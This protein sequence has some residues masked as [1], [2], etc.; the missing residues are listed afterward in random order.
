[1]SRIIIVITGGNDMLNI[2]ESIKQCLEGVELNNLTIEQKKSLSNRYNTMIRFEY[3]TTKYNE[4]VLK[5]NKDYFGSMEY[6]YGFEYE[7]EN[8]ILKIEYE[9]DLIVIYANDNHNRV[10]EL[11]EYLTPEQFCKE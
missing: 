7:R 2:L 5:M 3:S 8:I 10:T 9:E 4:M 11:F 1:M 6:Y